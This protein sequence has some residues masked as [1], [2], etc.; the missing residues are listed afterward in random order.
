MLTQGAI[1]SDSF[2]PNLSTKRGVPSVAASGD[3]IAMMGA[4]M[5]FKRNAEIY[6]E[7]GLRRHSA[8]LATAALLGVGALA[9]GRVRGRGNTILIEHRAM[10]QEGLEP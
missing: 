9:A 10:A 3:V 6:G 2:K 4:P 5:G 8:V 1:R 7:T